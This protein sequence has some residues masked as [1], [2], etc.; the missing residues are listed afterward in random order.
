MDE[1]KPVEDS[2]EAQDGLS[3]EDSK[4]VDGGCFPPVYPP[5]IPRP[6]M[7]IDFVYQLGESVI[8]KYAGMEGVVVA[9]AVAFIESS[10]IYLVEVGGVREKWYPERMLDA[11][12]QFHEPERPGPGH[13]PGQ[14]G[15]FE[16]T[17]EKPSPKD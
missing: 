15:I 1:K 5:G 6:A 16:E 14:P 11:A 3:T 8:V 13:I 12:M 10:V 4:M 9:A 2:Q 7:T 17:A